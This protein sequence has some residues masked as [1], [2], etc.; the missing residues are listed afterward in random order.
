[1]KDIFNK[2]QRFSIRKF[3]VGVASVL[4]GIALFTPSQGVL[5]S[6]EN[7]LA[8]EIGANSEKENATPTVEKKEENQNSPEN[9]DAIPSP[10]P[11][12]TPII[13]TRT[14]ELETSG[15][16]ENNSLTTRASVAGE[17]RSSAPAVRAASNPSEIKKYELTEEDAKKIKAG[18]IG[19]EGNKLDS[20]LL[21]GPEL[22][23]EA[24]TDNDYLK[25]KEEL[26]IY[27]K[28]GKKY[29]GYNSHP[30]L[31]DT[32]GDG[33]IDSK[34]KPDEKLKW[35]VSERDM[36]M[37]ME[38]SYR[39]DNYID[40]VLDHKKPLTES[41]LYKNNGDSRPRYEYMM[42]NKELGPYWERKKSYHTSSG[43][44][45]VLYETKSDFSYLPNGTAQV[46]AFRGTSDA[47]DIGTDITLGLGS[48]P[49]QGIDA[50][51]IMRELAK[52]KSITNLYLT[53]HSLGGYLVQRAMVEAYQLAYSDSRVMSSKDQQAYRNFYNNV[54]KKGTTF[55]APKVR[56]NYFSSS[57]F[58]QKG[59]DSK[60]IAKS[61]KMTHY[62][63]DNDSTIS[64][65]VSNDSDVVINVGRTSGGH[66]SRSYFEADMINRRSE[67]ISG[68]R[69][70]L[71]R[72]GYQD[73]K[74]ATA[75]SVEKVGE[76]VVYSKRG[77]DIIKSTTVSIKDPD[78]GQITKN[79]LNE[80]FKKDGAKSTVVVTSLEPIVRY[81]KDATR[82]KGE[83]NVTTAGTSGARTV[84]TTYTVNPTDGSLV[85][86]EEPAVVVPSKPTVVKVPAK[87]EVEYLKEGDDVV[88]K[89]TTYE[90]NAST[91]NLAPT[92]KKEIFKQNGAKAKFVVTP[93]QPS[94]RYEKDST[95][96]RGGENVTIAG[97]PGTRTVTITYTVNP[98][99]GRLI[100]HEGKPVIK[101]SIPTV[102]KVP[103]KDEV[104]YLKEGDNV[105]KKTTT[106]EVNAITGTLT[107]TEK[108]EI[109]KQNGAK[110]KV[111]VTPLQPS[112]RY[113]KD[114]TRARGGENVTI[115]GTPGTRTVTTTYTVNPTNGRLIPHEGKPVIKSSIPTV[116]KVPAKDEVEYLKEGDDVVKKTTS[117][118]VNASTGTLTP[119]EKKE[120]FKQNSA[121]S[122][123][124]VTPIEPSVRYEKDTT[125]AKGEANVTIAGTQ[126]TS[127]VTTT[128]TVNPT[129]GSLIPHEGQPV[130]KPSTPTVVRVP[131]KDEVE[132]LKE[133]DDV[134]KKITTYAVD[135]N[136]GSLT[137]TE[138][139]EIF[140]QNGAKSTVVVTQ[141]EPSVRYEKDATRA[142]GGETITVAG[143]PGTSTVT[144]TYTVNPT[145]GSLIPHEGKPVIK[146]STPTVVKVPAQD[147]VEYLKEGDDVVKK[148][149]SYEVNVSTGSLTPTEKKE[150]FKQDGAQST[151]VVTS[152]E[153]SVRYEK[154]A[155]KV[156]GEANITT[157][158]TQG[159]STVTTTYTVNSTAGS[160]IPHEGLAVVVP[161]T[162]TVVKVPAKDEVEYLKEGDDV[163]KKTITYAVDAST[164]SLTPTETTEIF[165][166][167]G[168]K[169][170]VVVTPL[171]PSVRYEKDATKAKGGET[172]TVA[173]TPGTRTVT[174]TYTVNP[175]D[176]LLIPHEEPAVEVP[177]TPTVIKVPAKDEIEYLKDGDDVVKK[178]ITYAVDASTGALTST[179]TTEIFTQNVAKSKVV[180]TQIEQSVRYEK[181]ATR[182]K[183]GETITVAGTPGTRTV[184]TTYTVNP[185]DGSLIPH[186]E[187]AVAVPSTPTVVKVPAKDE[188]EYLRDGDDVV[189][190]TTSYEVNASTGALT[191]TV[192]KDI[193][194]PNG[195]KSTVVVT[196]L[197]PSVRYEKDATR[198]KGEANATT[199]GTPGTRT[200][201][202]TYT[203][204]PT[205]GSLIPH[206][207]PAVVVPST[208]TVVKVPAKDEIEYL[209]D[210][211]DV[212]KKTKTYEVNASTGALTPTVRKDI[213]S[214][215]G[216]KSK[217]VTKIIPVTTRYEADKTK[218]VGTNTVTNNGSEGKIVTTTSTLVNATNG[219]VTDGTPVVSRTEM[220]PKV[221]KVGAKDK[222]VETLIEPEVEYVKDVE[223]D[224][225]TPDQ[226]TE[227]EK[228]KTVTT[229]TYDVDPKDGHIT[230]YVGNPVVIP[231]GK[232]IVKVG[233]KTKVEQSKDPEGRDVIDTTIYEVDPKTGKVTPTTVRTYGTTKEST[234]E[235][236]SVPSPVVY[237]KDDSR[238]KDS[239]PVRKEGTPGEETI[240][241]TYTVDP[242]TGAITPIVG[243]PVRTKE[244]TNTIVK[245]A[246]KDKV[247]T[248]EIPSP[249]KY[250]K[251]DTRDKGQGN[252]EE[253]GQAG[254]RTTTTTYEVN[255][256][257]GT[258]TERV[259]EPV[260][261]N[262]T[263]TIVKVPAKDKVVE[264]L[265]EP[266]V[267]YVKDVEK[268]FGTPTQRTEGEKGKTITTTTYDVDPKDGHITEHVGNLVVIPAG[269]TIVKVGVK[270]KVEQSKDP[271]GRD[272]IDTTTYE[273]DPKTGKVTPT[274]TTTYGPIS[275]KG[276][277]EVQTEIPEYTN[278][279]SSNGVDGN[280]N[281]I[282][283]PTVELPEFKGGVNGELPGS[284][285]LPELTIEVHWIDENGNVLKP[286]VKTGSEKDAEHGSIPG[287]E[288]VRTVIAENEPVLTH[289]FSKVSGSTHSNLATPPKVTIFENGVLPDSIELPELMID[290]RWID[291]D[292]NVLKPSVKSGN[293][294][295][296]E[297]GS[298]LGYEFVRTVIAENE[299]VLTHIFR[300]VSG[301]TNPNTNPNTIPVTP[302]LPDTNGNSGHDTLTPT[303]PAPTPIPDAVTPN[304]NHEDTTDFIDNRAK[305]NNSQNVL[306]NTGTESNVTLASL[307]LLGM[308]GGLGLAFGK[309]KKTK[310][311]M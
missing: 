254:S 167:N 28:G 222:V 198:A 80:V 239:E 130:I 23:P 230:A 177:S 176:G 142:K 11:K 98:T 307:G 279:I 161:P 220:V 117:Y 257:D 33:I 298:I 255:P 173:G 158:G 310:V 29:V 157:A 265:I 273:V 18:V 271:E 122:T 163:V 203:V 209:K 192:R 278:P 81:E 67:F 311:K 135:A 112:V 284:I 238:D 166:R 101:S 88:K 46:L 82:P 50:E 268:D 174:T 106:Y 21:N 37:F 256:A 282:D 281:L 264:T 199:A 202:T 9:Q 215:N 75:K 30:L 267:E 111:V 62:I 84:T 19:S 212:V 127:T 277:P 148:I 159:T 227:G 292:G 303:I 188:I 283:P 109:F 66:S 186:E 249:K 22:S 191:P 143:I 24:Y 154:D 204:N 200:V 1:M 35:N 47:K 119:T 262:P 182:S 3:S 180:V 141:L 236:R 213:A 41:E 300:K 155:T 120:I 60:K 287:Y 118:A 293:E 237:E 187:S 145:D 205:D 105:V 165:K 128:Y 234:T 53:G 10:V 134:V 289:I 70:S 197:E 295:D 14:T 6:T 190:K 290:V 59:L 7:N 261:V 231:A 49:Q 243:D 56:T 74:I 232:T 308:L 103:A 146:S 4:I 185:T 304:A 36:I 5:A 181:D 140:T 242:K 280:R 63:V 110:A 78:T 96:A 150:V 195:A 286:S 68:K 194:S 171:E 31:E 168:A 39:D 172:V 32:D 207:E 216:V 97:T 244:P 193:T 274:T 226:R 285:T 55:N 27:E 115:A 175:T 65:G 223:K 131:A 152:I 34:E 40:R 306:P 42:M 58:W 288:F 270:T 79:T 38:L 245:V 102:V 247:E 76:T 259:G 170:K 151:V 164:G 294:K 263:A 95:R 113:D 252:V 139:T 86:H 217:V 61:G 44:D 291:E 16:K 87:D 116:V 90:V 137:P 275:K 219:T 77:D 178:T 144:T 136:T 48:N 214:P 301:S 248:T 71:D 241:T 64:K 138:I 160:L 104:E 85:S 69:I 57:E 100:P 83:A 73:K 89:T 302:V 147:E 156:K 125:R 272:V 45:A 224:F 43:L 124:V 210:G 2:R 228:G 260:V 51:N 184:T 211:D 246:A 12:D 266:E 276:E 114:A 299:P 8:T 309:K 240:T 54:L 233:V 153:P 162:P 107:P 15:D 206:E 91:G 189:K 169:S 25:D 108:K 250:V 17:D 269:K 94:V 296:A 225:G 196:P 235:T 72:T 13:S 123:V 121:K 149:T 99:N 305:S 129:D 26:Y 221:V 218:D 132:Y 297:H 253:A 133:G 52:D 93:I 258:I 179:E 92:E 183:G 201:T 208:P 229:T 251:D 20:L 126:G